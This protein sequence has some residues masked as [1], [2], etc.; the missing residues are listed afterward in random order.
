MTWTTRVLLT[1][2][3][4]FWNVFLFPAT[5]K[6]FCPTIIA[7]YVEDIYQMYIESQE[8]G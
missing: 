2:W 5:K 4:I 1:V 7:E 8:K 6:E 3:I